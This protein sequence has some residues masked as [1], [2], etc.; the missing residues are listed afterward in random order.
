[1]S[2]LFN[3]TVDA[4]DDIG[5]PAT[6][7]SKH[8]TTSSI[9][10]EG[11]LSD[12]SELKLVGK[13]DRF[14]NLL[15]F[16]HKKSI[17]YDT[18]EETAYFNTLRRTLETYHRHRDVNWGALLEQC[19]FGDI[20]DHLFNPRFEYSGITQSGT[21][22]PILKKKGDNIMCHLMHADK[23]YEKL[24][25]EVPNVEISYISNEALV[26]TLK[27]LFKDL[28]VLDQM[29][30]LYSKNTNTTSGELLVVLTTLAHV[31]LP[32]PLAQAMLGNWRLSYDNSE[33]RRAIMAN[34][35]SAARF[36]L[37]YN[38]LTNLGY[39]NE[40]LNE[41]YFE[42]HELICLNRFLEKDY[43][44]VL[45]MSLF[46]IGQY[47]QMHHDFDSAT[48]IWEIGAHMSGDTDC[49]NMAIWG[50]MDGF[51]SSNIKGVNKFSSKYKASKFVSKRRIAHLYRI[52]IK[53]GKSS[54][55]GTSWVWKSKYD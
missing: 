7:S 17:R 38:N 15:K 44:S 41:E 28:G 4:A 40:V 48:D 39:F 8:S 18:P 30:D 22:Y 54:E 26:Q 50:L 16:P 53:S 35:R 36:G 31:T 47:L 34:F 11:A 29:L 32:M 46:N 12:D 45:G 37:L 25:F 9:Y 14:K 42:A 27:D 2:A 10:S 52:L 23:S 21:T 20:I 19:L 6:S 24:Q 51:G 13:S 1:M 5:A 43:K 49:C 55:I 33:P 3:I